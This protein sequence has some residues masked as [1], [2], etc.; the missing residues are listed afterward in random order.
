MSEFSFKAD[1]PVGSYGRSDIFFIIS[2]LLLWGL[3]I[4][5][6]YVCTPYTAERLFGD[7]YYFVTRQLV[8]SGIGFAL[9][10]FFAVV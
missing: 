10:V 8:W 2:V 1:R 5:T 3:G 4:F 6:L 9:M 7:R